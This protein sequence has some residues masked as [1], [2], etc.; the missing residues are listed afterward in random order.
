M[1]VLP[2]SQTLLLVL[3]T[4]EVPQNLLKA[5]TVAEHLWYKND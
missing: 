1:R 2:E 5:W 3:E 4:A